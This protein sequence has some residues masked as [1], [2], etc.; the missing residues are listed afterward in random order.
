MERLCRLGG[1][2]P[3]PFPRKRRD[4]E[5][6]VKSLLMRLDSSRTYSEPEIND[7]LEEWNRQVVPAIETDHVTVRR[8]L[9]DSGH[10]ERTADGRAYRVGFP[11]DAVAFDLEIDGIDLVAMIRAHRDRPRPKR[12]PGR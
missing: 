4:R 9:V 2:R 8:L 10:L 1:E 12:P 11:I 5:I 6:L 3:R 7:L